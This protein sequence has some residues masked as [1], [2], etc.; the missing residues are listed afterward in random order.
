[1]AYYCGGK[2]SVSLKKA[3]TKCRLFFPTRA[4][5]MSPL[6]LFDCI[7]KEY[8]LL[9]LWNDEVRKLLDQEITGGVLDVTY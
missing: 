8:D 7:V 3:H 1:M 5:C 4:E 6:E 2:A 9:V